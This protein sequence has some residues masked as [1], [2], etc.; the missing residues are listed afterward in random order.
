MK[1]LTAL[2]AAALTLT[3]YAAPRAPIGFMPVSEIRPGMTGV[4]RTVFAGSERSDFKVHVLGVLRNVMAPRRDL[5]LARL[6]GGPLAHTGVLEG[7][8]GSPVYIDGRL[9]GAVSYSLG[10]FP[11]E[12]IA[13]ITPIDEMIGAVATASPRAPATRPALDLPV[14]PERLTA[15]LRAMYQRV[16]PF[17][18]RPGDLDVIGLPRAA[19]ALGAQLRP[20]A[21]PL[22]IGGFSGQAW[23]LLHDAFQGAGFLP[24]SGEFQQAEPSPP[25]DLQ[26]GDALGV[27]L[28]R[29]DY[30][31]GA[32]GTVTHVDGTRV[33]AFG[34][35]FFNL[36]PTQ[37]PMTRARVYTLLPSLMTSSKIAAIGEV[38]G[39]VEQDRATAIGGTIGPGP[40][41]IPVTLALD[42]G[43]GAARTLRFEV[44]HDEFFTPLLT[45]LTVTSSLVAYERQVGSAT[46]AIKGSARVAGHGAIGYE[47]VVSGPDA[48]SAAASYIAGPVAALMSNTLEPVRFEGLDLSIEATEQLRTATLERAWIDE[49]RPR[50]GQTVT[51]KMLVRA[52]GGDE[53][54]H[55]IPVALPPNAPASLSI[56]VADG[57]QLAQW[58]QRELKRSDQPVTV[59]Q[60]VSRLNDTRRHDRLYVRL[61]GASPGAVVNGEPLP[62]LPP[63]VLSVLDAERAG[64]RV[65]PIRS[66]VLGSWEIPVGRAVTGSRLITVNIEPAR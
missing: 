29:G 51:L 13:G 40:R 37:F 18:D 38:I 45:F 17:A 61:F 64:G 24:L 21:T 43:R 59:A 3:A 39:T 42:S 27:S 62:S 10:A 57:P 2:A 41:L 48:V 49:P 1:A 52:Y 28:L 14:T 31:L 58:E 35:P 6:E 7:M 47:D 25:G 30:E 4:G 32:T 34:H 19:G 63:S 8:S 56:L 44:A 50:S 54:V 5:I 46:F 66:A 53:R 33:Y 16:R 60:M 23:D 20:I 15:A 36:G 12:P 11:K 22:V 65:A 55:S 26:P 9:I